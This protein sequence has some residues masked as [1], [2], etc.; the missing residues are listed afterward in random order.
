MAG[1]GRAGNFELPEGV[2]HFFEG[3]WD[4]PWP[5]VESYR[6]D[7]SVVVRAELPGMEPGH[8]A[9]VSISN[10]VLTIQGERRQEMEHKDNTGYRSEFRYGSFS[11]S[12]ALAS[13]SREDGAQASYRDGVLEI[14]VPNSATGQAA[15]SKVRIQRH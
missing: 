12:I 5:R 9:D 2:R 13:G 10:G 4:P 1:F 8:D 3:D 7:E 11:R 15:S 6:A 14:R